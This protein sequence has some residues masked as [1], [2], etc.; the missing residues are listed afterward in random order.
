MRSILGSVIGGISQEESRIISVT[1]K[2]YLKQ[3]TVLRGFAQRVSSERPLQGPVV[4][5][6]A[7]VRPIQGRNAGDFSQRVSSVRH[8]QGLVA[9]DL[10]QGAISVILT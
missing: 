8:I 5:E 1:K 6:I 4:G 2:R 7:R 3:D 9:G 10:A